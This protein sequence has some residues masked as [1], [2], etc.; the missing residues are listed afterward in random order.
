MEYANS[1]LLS[2]HH[3]EEDFLMALRAL[4]LAGF[5]A[6]L[7]GRFRMTPKGKKLTLTIIAAVNVRA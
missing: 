6:T 3:D 5:Q 4:S 7:I 2:S 1:R